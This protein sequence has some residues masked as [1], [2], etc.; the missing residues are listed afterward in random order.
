MLC[1]IRRNTRKGGK[2]SLFHLVLKTMQE[3]SVAF[4][5]I[6]LI[7]ENK[8]QNLKHITERIETISTPCSLIV[9]PEMFNTGFSMNSAQLAEEMSGITISWMR[10]LATIKNV[11][12]CGSLII[13]EQN[14]Y[15]N[16][17]VWMNPDGNC[18]YYNKRHL[19]RMANENE[20]YSSGEHSC[21][22]DYHGWKINLQVCYDLR[23]PVWS[24]R[25]AAN[26]YDLLLYVANWPERRSY[27]WKQLLIARAIEN[28]S[29][30]L[31]VNRVGEDG[32]NI[33][34][35]GDSAAINFLGDVIE[36]GTA[37]E[38]NVLNV[39]FKKDELYAYRKAFPAYL[40]ADSFEI[41]K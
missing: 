31:G 30:V 2:N 12:I 8:P 26:E 35:S 18:V 21:I 10:D 9:L 19:F 5:Q 7:W 28:Q 4:L 33:A 15:Y 39:T 24:R 25:T 3:L 23:F 11:A 32:N 17:L 22:V 40:D 14:N 41:K 38:E 27:A 13:K 34:Y 37:H 29:Y 36:S 20:Y 16:R 1:Q 6:P